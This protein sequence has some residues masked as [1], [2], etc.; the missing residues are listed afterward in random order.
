MFPWKD[1]V[2]VKNLPAFRLGDRVYDKDI[3]VLPVEQMTTININSEGI[4]E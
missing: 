3:I 4:I 1:K 2:P